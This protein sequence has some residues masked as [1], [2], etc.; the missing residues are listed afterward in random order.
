MLFELKIDGVALPAPSGYSFTESDLVVNSE[1]N[2]AGYASWDLVRSNVGS[3]NI[4]WENVSR[5]KVVKII[6]AIRGKKTFRATFLNT[7]TGNM[8]TRTFYAGDR[9]NELVRYVSS[10]SYWSS[11]TIPFVEV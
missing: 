2:A 6:A 7:N 8:E 5:E 3:L 4:T 9:A 11:L 10:L 1:R